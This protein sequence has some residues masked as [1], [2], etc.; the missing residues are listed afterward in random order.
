MGS[1]IKAS[2]YLNHTEKNIH[3]VTR[4]VVNRQN[5]QNQSPGG[6]EGQT[7]SWARQA[8]WSGRQVQS[9]ETGK[10]Q[11]RRTRKRIMQK[12]EREKR[13]LTWKHTRRT[14]TERQETQG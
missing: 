5:G 1:L 11:N 12:A 14:G 2:Q 7:G 10:G 8:E 9:P 13:W 4:M 6:T 3:H